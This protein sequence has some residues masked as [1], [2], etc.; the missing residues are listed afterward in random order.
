MKLELL[1]WALLDADAA[2][3]PSGRIKTNHPSQ[4]GK[5]AEKLWIFWIFLLFF[6]VDAQNRATET[7]GMVI[8][9]Q[10]HFA[11]ATFFK[12]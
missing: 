3:G 7:V 6:S 9:Y 2:E 5:T 10:K 11:T 1:A 4:H 8:N 12:S